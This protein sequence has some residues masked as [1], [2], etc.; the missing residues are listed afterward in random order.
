MSAVGRGGTGTAALLLA[1]IVAA[2][3]GGGGGP[4]AAPDPGPADLLSADV[5][6]L[7]G[8]DADARDGTLL[9]LPTDLPDPGDETTAG[10][11]NG[12]ESIAA[13]PIPGDVDPETLPLSPVDTT[14]PVQL[15]DG[16]SLRVATLNV[17]GFHFATPEEIGAWL[18]GQD[19]DLAML[20]EIGADT[21]ARVATAAGFPYLFAGGGDEALLSKTPLD[22]P[23]EVPLVDGRGL[24]HATTVVEDVTFSVYAAHISWHVEG[25]LQARQIAREVMAADPLPHLVLAGDFNDE[26]YSTQNNYLDEV[27]TDA[28]TSMGWYPGQHITWPSTGFDETEG[29]QTIDLVFFRKALP[30]IV[31]GLAVLNLSPV[32]SDHKP[33]VAD[34]LYPREDLPFASDP[35]AAGRDPFAAFPPAGTRTPNLLV[36]PGAEDGL[37]G[38]D[39]GGGAQAAATCQQLAPRTGTA[40]FKGFDTQPDPGVPWSWATQVVD[41]SSRAAPIDAG[42][43]RLYASA[44]LATGY[45]TVEKDGEVSNLLTTYSDGEVIVETLDATGV[46]LSRTVS[47]R[48]DTLA[49]HP[50][51][52][53][54]DVPPGARAAR[55][56][57]MS[58]YKSQGGDADTAAVDDLY[59]GFEEVA[60]A[61][62]V[63]GGTLV[64]GGGKPGDPPALAIPAG[65]AAMPDGQPV[66]P[67]GITLFPPYCASGKA[68]FIANPGVDP[69]TE[70]VVGPAALTRT[71]DLAPWAADVDAGRLAIRWAASLR[72]FSALASVH[73]ALVVLDADGSP[74]ATF[75]SPPLQAAEWTRVVQL[76]RMPPNARKVRIEVRT[77]LDRAD[78]TVFADEV[79]LVPERVPASE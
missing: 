27:L 8:A 38:W 54:V 59:L 62:R 36:N 9:D 23:A 45:R 52:A 40:L 77:P 7:D 69:D 42:R 73:L 72:T 2:C 60:T 24:I 31:K 17:Y 43:G 79:S 74:W 3:G 11:A 19:A 5:E 16:V 48:R 50:F 65:W 55:V 44:W 1:C 75:E 6:T 20:E 47:G 28:A 39:V 22:G 30:A 58:H 61:H 34:L 64:P 76:T 57:W 51:A 4:G 10:D 71:V 26:H 63:L 12:D 37:S 32:L 14:P 70:P 66:G 25:N 35:L 33:V 13:D 21:A 67:W 53:V 29:A 46:A 41:L 18:G 68:C 56:T 78:D 49:W 15:P